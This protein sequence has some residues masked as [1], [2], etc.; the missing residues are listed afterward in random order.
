[1]L[2]SKDYVVGIGAQK[3]GTTWL[4]KYLSTRYEVLLSPLKEVHYFDAQYRKDL[5]EIWDKTYVNRFKKLAHQQSA[6]AIMN[7]AT[8]RDVLDA[9][10]DRVRMIDDK[11]FYQYHFEKRVKAHHKIFGEVTPSY[12]VMN[13][14]GFRAMRDT[15]RNCKVIFLM[16]DPVDRFWSRLKMIERDSVKMGREYN[17]LERFEAELDEPQ[18]VARSAYHKT[19]EI[20][21]R[22]FGPNEQLT[23]FYEELFDDTAVA[24]LCEFLQL[25]FKPGDY[26]ERVNVSDNANQPTPEMLKLAAERFS[27]T[28]AYV[29][30]YFDGHLPEAWRA[31]WA[32]VKS[33]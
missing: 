1:M 32:H 18:N 19:L 11:Y 10:Y 28:Y 8:Q 12:A 21:K 17:A 33:S 30:E 26:D 2:S 14:D 7:D 27:P 23:M 16:R 15:F 31:S 25:D 6:H 29:E 13:E 3:S 20:M 9:H 5:C 4:F 24:R 22:V